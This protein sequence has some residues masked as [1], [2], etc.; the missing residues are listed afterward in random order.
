MKADL[1]IIDPQVDFCDPTGSLF[2]PGADEDMNRLSVM[3]N[4][5]RGKLNDIHV[6]MDTHHLFDIAH[7]LFWKD[8][9]GNHPDPFT[10]ISVDDVET[11]KWSTTHASMNNYAKDYVKTLEMNNRYILIIWPPHCLIGSEGYKVYPKLYDEL[12]LWE[13]ERVSIVNYVTKGSNFKTEHYSVFQADVPDSSDPSTQLNTSLIQTLQEVDEIVVAGEA[14][15]HCVAM[16]IT[17]LADNIGDEHLKKFVLLTDAMS[18]VATFEQNGQD[19]LDSMTARGM[20]LSTTE[21]YLK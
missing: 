19:F 8:S 15:S 6:T 7:P 1:L 16:S 14:L 13:K 10:L 17:D 21:E 9:N 12:I 20:R 11:G 5:L 3:V 2:V 18:S 4:R